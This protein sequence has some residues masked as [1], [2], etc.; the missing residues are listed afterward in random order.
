MT[1]HLGL[2]IRDNLWSALDRRQIAISFDLP[3]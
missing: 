2:D 1:K 3:N